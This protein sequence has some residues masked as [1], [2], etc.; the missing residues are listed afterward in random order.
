MTT[1]RK[2]G[3][4]SRRKRPCP[5]WWLTR[6]E[7]TERFLRSL[8]GVTVEEI[9]RSAGG[10]PILAAAFG[11][12]EDLPKRTSTSLASAL[13]GGSSAAFYGDGER[14]RQSLLFVGNAHGIEFEGTVAALNM[15]NVLVTGKDLRGRSWPEMRRAGRRLRVVIIP[16]LNIDGRARFPE[17]RHFLDQDAESYRRICQGDWKSGEKIVWP[18]SKLFFPI[19][20]SRVSPLGAYFNDNG[21]NLVYDTGLGEEPQPETR[22]LLKFCRQEMPDCAVCSHTDHGSLVQPPD[23]FIPDYYR[24]RQAQIG[25][26]VSRRCQRD[27]TIRRH[28][29][30]QRTMGYAGQVLYQTDLIYH[31]CGALP[32]LVEFPVGYKDFPYRFD[33]VL[34]IGMSVLEEILLFAEAD[35]FRPQ[36]SR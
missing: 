9:G 8:R 7:E 6:P 13:A 28:R 35:R 23:S 30:P 32:L 18:Q 10:R 12:R 5:A 11:K 14:R 26:M 4:G 31:T 21:V 15:L 29:I 19:P 3:S 1:R 22:A 2:D 17:V 33:E 36:N 20:V 16:H 27:G 25:A 24:Q 34:D